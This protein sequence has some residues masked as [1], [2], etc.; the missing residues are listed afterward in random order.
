M[1]ARDNPFWRFSLAVDGRDGVP[2]ACVSL[3]DQCGVDV[4]VLLYLLYRAVGGEALRPESVA[5]LDASVAVWRRDVV[6]AI[7]TAR[8]A[9]KSPELAALAADDDALRNRV[10]AVELEA[11][12][13]QQLALYRIGADIAADAAEPVAAA[14]ASLDAYAAHL[15]AAFPAEAARRLIRAA[16]DASSAP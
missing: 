13:L 16:V 11:E 14:Q 6:Q 2:E 8:R 1:D 12:R 10:K 3:Q 9:L 15:G 5:R 4:N 7:R